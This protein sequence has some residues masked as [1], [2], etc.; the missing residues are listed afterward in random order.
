MKKKYFA[1]NVYI[2]WLLWLAPLRKTTWWG[3]PPKD[4][5]SHCIIGQILSYKCANV[6]IAGL[7]DIF[8]KNLKT[9]DFEITRLL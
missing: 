2:K 7:C 4:V 6:P 3:I 1:P 8:F 9:L 5:Q